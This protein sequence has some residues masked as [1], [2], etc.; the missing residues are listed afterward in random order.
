LFAYVDDGKEG[1][2]KVSDQFSE[3]F[4]AAVAFTGG[5]I[6]VHAAATRESGVAAAVADVTTTTTTATK[7]PL[8]YI[9]LQPTMFIDQGEVDDSVGDA[10]ETKEESS[11]TAG[12]AP[13]VVGVVNSQAALLQALQLYSRNFF[14]PSLKD[15]T[16]LQEKI[17]QLNVAIGQSQRT[18]KLPT[19]VLHV[20]SQIELYK[21]SPDMPLPTPKL[22]STGLTLDCNISCMM[23][24]I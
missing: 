23:M 2:A 6:G 20:D 8:Q 22:M 3:K 11:D 24:I 9:T 7:Q 18:A 1:I 4:L 12:S 19:V 16:I 14:L 13:D 21:P 15:Q 5:P 17:R 10:G